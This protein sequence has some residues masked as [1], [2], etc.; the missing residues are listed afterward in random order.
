MQ[1]SPAVTAEIAPVAMTK[2]AAHFN[3]MAMMMNIDW[4]VF[5][6]KEQQIPADSRLLFEYSFTPTQKCFASAPPKLNN[7]CVITFAWLIATSKRSIR[8][9]VYKIIFDGRE[10]PIRSTKNIYAKY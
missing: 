8:I 6:E 4:Q 7:Y 3:L 1:A 5:E 10:N 9:F 2:P